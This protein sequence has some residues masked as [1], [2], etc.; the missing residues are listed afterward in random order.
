M[1][2]GT[3]IVITVPTLAIIGTLTRIY[4]V[5]KTNGSG[6]NGHMTKEAKES[7]TKL[8]SEKQSKEFCNERSEGIKKDIKE[9][10]NSQKVT[11][12]SMQN[13]EQTIIGWSRPG[14]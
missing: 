11:Q 3:A 6:G 10:K 7:T 1:D 2:Y 5:K 8:W 12:D 9:I 13:I 4:T 14:G